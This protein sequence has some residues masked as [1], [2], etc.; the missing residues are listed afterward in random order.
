MANREPSVISIP[1]IS[2]ETTSSIC[3]GLKNPKISP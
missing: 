1:E 2:P 3:P